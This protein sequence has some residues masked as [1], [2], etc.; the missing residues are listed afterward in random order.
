LE[1]EIAGIDNAQY[2]TV[3]V[4]GTASLGGELELALI[5]GFVPQQQL[6]LTVLGA[7]TNIIG[8]FA[9]VASGQR[10]TTT[11]GLGSFLVHYG[12]ASPFDPRHVVLT[13]FQTSALAG[14]F[15]RDG[16]ADAADYVIWRR[17]LSGNSFVDDTNYQAWRTNFGRTAEQLAEST[18]VPE[19]AALALICTLFAAASFVWRARPR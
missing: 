14:D 12:T 3:G 13:N 11:D 7:S 9:N 16:T 19:P 18:S 8:A 15:N 17:K 4:M 6:I 2:D 10:L 5:N 1:I